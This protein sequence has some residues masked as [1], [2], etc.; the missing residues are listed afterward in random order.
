MPRL[1]RRLFVGWLGAVGASLGLPSLRRGAHAAGAPLTPVAPEPHGDGTSTGAMALDP[2]MVEAIATVVLPSALGA[3]GHRRASATFL[4]WLAGYRAG[5]EL[6]HGYGTAEIR[7]TAASPEGRW[8]EQLAALDAAARA[9]HARGF[10]A[11]PRAERE[12]L[13]REALA[14]ERGARL[15]APLA[16]PHVALALLAHWAQ[17]PEAIDLCHE[18]RIARQQCRPLVNAPK[19]PVPLERPASGGRRA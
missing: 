2:A 17:S 9:R 1:S 4:R 18:A 5:A 16:A 6:V 8:R 7:S 13:V 14:G 3:D 19:E 12:T 15:P 10:A 11:L